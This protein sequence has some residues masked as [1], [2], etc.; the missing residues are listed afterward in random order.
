ML[1]NFVYASQTPWLGV[2]QN[3]WITANQKHTTSAA[4][5]TIIISVSS[6]SY[7]KIVARCTMPYLYFP[8][9][10]KECFLTWRRSVRSAFV[11]F[12]W[13][14]KAL[15]TFPNLSWIVRYSLKPDSLVPRP[16]G[17]LGT[18]LWVGQSREKV[19]HAQI[20]PGQMQIAPVD[21]HVEV[22][23][24]YTYCTNYRAFYNNSHIFF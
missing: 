17:N 20:L 5:C 4:T 21:W 7:G 18:R 10:H 12:P 14:I 2:T 9:W 22:A 11:R 15:V 6:E 13:L 23:I 19:G 24:V 1:Y 3:P 8:P 16:H